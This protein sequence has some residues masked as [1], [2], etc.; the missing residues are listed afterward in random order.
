MTASSSSTV[1]GEANLTFN[2]TQLTNTGDIKIASGALGVNTNPLSDNGS[3]VATNDIIA[4]Q[5]GGSVAMTIND[6]GG[7]ANLTF[8]HRNKT[9]DQN[10]QSARIEVNVDATSTEGIMY[11]ETSTAD[12]TSGSAVTL[13]NA[14]TLTHDYMD[15]PDKIRHMGDTDTYMQFSAADTWK[16]YCGGDNPLTAIANRVYVNA[17]GANG[18]LINNDEGNSA[19]S[20]RIFFEGTSTTALMQQ[21]ND[22]SIR[23]GATTGSSSGTERFF[24]NSSG[25]SVVGD[26]SVSGNSVLQYG[27]VVNEGSHDA[28]FRAESNGYANA[29]KVDAGADR[30]DV[31]VSMKAE[32]GLHMDGLNR[33][34]GNAS[35]H[36]L[37]TR[38]NILTFSDNTYWDGAMIINTDITRASSRMCSI[39]VQGYAYGEAEIIDFTI[40]FYTY[41]G[42]NGQDGVAG[43]TYAPVC[44]DRGTDGH[45]KFVGINSDGNVA[46]AIDDYDGANKYYYGFKV[47]L[48]NHLNGVGHSAYSSWTVTKSTT[49]GFGW[50][51]KR[52]PVGNIRMDQRNV[53]IGLIDNSTTPDARL[54]VSENGGSTDDFFKV[55]PANGHNRTM[56][57]AGDAINVTVTGGSS[58]TLR[59]NEDGGDVAVYN[60]LIMAPTKKLYLDNGGDTYIFEESA[61]NVMFKVGNNNN[62]RFNSTGAIF[63]DGSIDLDFRVESN[64]DANMLFVD[65]GANRVGIGTGSPDSE[66]H[67]SNNTANL[68]IE[69]TGSGNAS[70]LHIK[71]TTNQYDIYNNAGD[72]VIDLNGVAE[73]MRIDSNGTLCIGHTSGWSSTVLDLGA[74]SNHMRVGGTIYLYDSNRYIRRNGDDIDYYSNSGS[75]NF[76]SG[77]VLIGH[78][79]EVQ[80][81]GKTAAFQVLGTGNGDS[82]LNIGRFSNNASAPML[83]FTKSRSGTIG[84][85]TVIQ[86]GDA[87]G[88]I[89]WA[90]ADGTDF[91]SYIAAIGTHV[92]GTPGGNDVPGRIEFNTTADGSAGSIEAMRLDSSQDA[93]FDQDVIA[94]STTPSDIRLKKNFTKIENGLDIVLQLEGHTFNWKKE[95]SGERLSAGFKAQEVEKILPHLVDEKKLPLRA[96]DDKEYK[97][98]RYEEMIPYLVEAIKEL[99]QQI[100]ELKNG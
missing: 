61:N 45:Q 72:L 15:I 18:L 41:S 79:T 27:L 2:G 57:I 95:R 55:N 77:N 75:H 78:N 53:G 59:L 69:S 20:A 88:T 8:N 17:S 47:T 25:A 48:D 99:K 82:H 87:C 97:I 58:T 54:V 56:E 4:G 19:D 70:Y 93:H 35:S 63:N 32:Y 21:G 33:A 31:G 10:G 44:L 62:L 64:G 26:L 3:I 1:N 38:H 89:G 66:L 9:P 34:G 6:G 40:S 67:V 12:V 28:D 29:L 39:H 60:H 86:N 84:T 30:V 74:T 91:E 16:V 43:Y 83:T 42:T 36:H 92:D 46:I 90:V 51:D 85:S 98:L 24:V 37:R 100:Q 96:D 80:T 81:I 50:L 49:D 11:F 76:T 94:F 14:M 52:I 23:S 22:F 68:K 5:G 65:G 71:N 7:N 73:R 13:A